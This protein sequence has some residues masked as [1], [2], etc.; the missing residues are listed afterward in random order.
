MESSECLFGNSKYK[1]G[2]RVCDENRCYVCKDGAW[3]ESFDS[4]VFGVGP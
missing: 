2:E 1:S 4:S 3:V